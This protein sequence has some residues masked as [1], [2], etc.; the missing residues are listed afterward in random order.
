MKQ[1]FITG[2]TG[3]DGA[4]LTR[5]LLDRGYT[6]HGAVRDSTRA[7]TSKLA[8][9]G[10]EARVTLHRL[11]LLDQASIFQTLREIAPDEIYNLAAQSSVAL[12]FE[13]PIPTLQ[14]NVL[15][16]TYL[17]EAIRLLGLSTRFYQ[18]SS[19]E[20]YGRV[21]HLPV[22]EETTLHPV[23][24]YAISK[25]AAHWAAINYRE[26]YGLYSCCGV[27][28][29]HE[30]VLRPKHFVTKKIV[31]AA[32]EI[33][34]GARDVLK[35]GNL[36][37]WRDWGWAPLYVEC[38]WLML[39]QETADDFIIATGEAHAL[40]EFVALAFEAVGLDAEKYVE[41]DP[42]LYR[43]ADIEKI[44]GDPSKARRVLDWQYS[45]SFPELVTRLVEAER[46]VYRAEQA[47]TTP[48]SGWAHPG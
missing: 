32:V 46:E 5:F 16:T 31:R 29:N 8:A 44:Y 22:T 2:I 24:P 26:A 36:D 47:G 21:P 14:F 38:M 40:R 28:F 1:A 34:E 39:Q 7:D 33:A 15:S 30:S 37:V 12:S 42:A 27:L 4:Y 20:M 25:A 11:N 19:S 43:P 10:V 6:V 17:L 35:L 48:R 9:L 23:S 45:V 13:Q 18:A 3:Q 41:I